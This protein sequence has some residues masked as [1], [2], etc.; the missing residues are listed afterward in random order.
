M[1]YEQILNIISLITMCIAGL[2]FV[3]WFLFKD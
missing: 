1:S 3:G 2:M